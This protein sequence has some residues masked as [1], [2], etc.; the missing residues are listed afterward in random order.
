MRIALFLLAIFSLSSCANE[1]YN[2]TGNAQGTTFNIT[3]HGDKAADFSREVEVILLSMD[4]SLSLWKDESFLSKVNA[5]TGTKI[6]VPSDDKFFIP[7]LTKSRDVYTESKGYFDPSLYPLIK[8]WGFGAV[9]KVKEIPDVNAL[10]Q[11]CGFGVYDAYIA[12]VGPERLFIKAPGR[13]FDFNGIAQGYTVD[14]I[15]NML[16]LNGVSDYMIELGGELITSGLKKDGSKWRIGIDDPVAGSPLLQ[17]ERKVRREIQLSDKAL[18][19]SGSYRKFYERD[20]KKYSHTIDPFTGS[21][22]NHQVLSVTVLMDECALADAY[23]TAFMCMG[24]E[25]TK[26]FLAQHTNMG[27]EVFII[28]NQ[29]DELQEYATGRF[30]ET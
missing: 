22:V 21:P 20:G 17:E 26:A 5:M 14:V 27:I 23:A 9:D 7:M 11:Q 6:G 30:K 2:L 28:Y 19:T 12:N 16:E 13:Q 25:K 10:K 4:A 18:A 1:E 29:D 3:Y 24:L 15:A 8:A